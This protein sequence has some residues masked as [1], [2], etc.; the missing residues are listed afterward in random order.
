ML[1]P[2]GRPAVFHGRGRPPARTER[3]A[4]RITGSPDHRITAGLTARPGG[5]HEDLAAKG[6]PD[7]RREWVLSDV[8][9]GE[10]SVDHD[11]GGHHQP[12][13]LHIGRPAAEEDQVAR[14]WWH[15]WWKLR[16]GV[17]LVLG[18][19]GQGDAGHL[20]GRLDQPR[21]VEADA[22]RF[23]TPDIRGADLGD[24]PFDGHGPARTR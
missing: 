6:G 7:G 19:P 12:D 22:G 10:R 11:A 23:A 15:A 21:T 17:E 9:T 18:H 5:T 14:C 13:V 20:V 16:S 2:I 1:V 24:G 4:S 8:G 3:P